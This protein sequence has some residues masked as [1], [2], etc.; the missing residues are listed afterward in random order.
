MA[1]PSDF[2]AQAD[3]AEHLRDSLESAWDDGQALA[4]EKQV[5]NDVWSSEIERRDS[6]DRVIAEAAYDAGM[7]RREARQREVEAATGNR[8]EE[9]ADPADGNEIR[10]SLIDAA[11]AADKTAETKAAEPE[12]PQAETEQREAPAA[13]AQPGAEWTAEDRARLDKMT[14]E[15]RQW[16]E[17]RAAA[18]R[19]TYGGVDALA[20]RW[21]P[22]LSQLGATTPQQQIGMLDSLLATERGLRTGSP[23]QRAAILAD[24]GRQYG[25][26]APAQAADPVYEARPINPAHPLQAAALASP[27]A[28]PGQQQHN[29]NSLRGRLEA[30]WQARRAAEQAR[31]TPEAQATAVQ[32]RVQDAHK[33]IAEFA[34]AKDE[35]GHPRHALMPYIVPEMTQAARMLVQAGHKPDLDTVY[36]AGLAYAKQTRPEVVEAGHA[37]AKGRVR[38]FKVANPVANDPQLEARMTSLAKADQRITGTVDLKSVLDRALKLE[39]HIAG[40]QEMHEARL[41]EHGLKPQPTLRQEL[42]AAWSA[43]AA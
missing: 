16:A 23:E 42:E 14:P 2:E 43:M 35:H 17:A 4:D 19:Q 38:A 20:E 10:K 22:Y 30:D 34:E 9:T 33:Q 26:G 11:E 39:P 3:N 12:K 25:A 1:L 27:Q 41:K 31:A 32:Q 8:I 21:S 28:A 40:R 5:S 29:P 13:D 7:M 15:D 37:D 36:K 6:S 18:V 24:L